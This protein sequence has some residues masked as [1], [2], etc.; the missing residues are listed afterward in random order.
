[1]D[2]IRQGAFQ[3]C[4]SCKSCPFRE[5]LKEVL[6]RIIHYRF[7]RLPRFLSCQYRYNSFGQMFDRGVLDSA[8]NRGIY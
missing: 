6:P 8:R 4:K 2:M 1:M 5:G 3:S 7:G